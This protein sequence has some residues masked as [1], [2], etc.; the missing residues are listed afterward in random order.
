MEMTKREYA[1]VI[2]RK[3]A[4]EVKEIEKTNGVIMTGIMITN[5]TN[6]APTFYIDE[7]YEKDV[8]ANEAA[9][10]IMEQIENGERP[11]FDVSSINSWDSAKEM[12]RI[13]LYNKK[14]TA[15]IQRSARSYGFG[16]L[17]MVPY[18]KFNDNAAAKVTEA[19]AEKWGKSVKAIIDT[20]LLNTKEKEKFEIIE[21]AAMLSEMMGVPVEMLRESAPPIYV[22]TNEARTNG[23]IGIIILEDKLKEMYPNGYYILPSSVHEAIVIDSAFCDDLDMLTE[24]VQDVNGLCVRPEEVLGDKA[25]IRED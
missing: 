9:G 18:I 8:P 5:D 6:I 2:A 7:M 16:D 13:R 12:L 14:T 1:E 25:Y 4:G 10:I 22:V 11:Q 20:A 19:L 24:M 21:M 17:I 15:P 3:V 23:A